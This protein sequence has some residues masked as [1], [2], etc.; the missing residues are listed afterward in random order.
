MFPQVRRVLATQRAPP[1]RRRVHLAH[2]ALQ[3]ALQRKFLAAALAHE[4]L[5]PVRQHML[6][7]GVQGLGGAAAVVTGMRALGRVH[8]RVVLE[9]AGV[10]EGGPA[11]LAGVRPLARVYAPVPPEGGTRG[12]QT[13]AEGASEGRL[14]GVAAPVLT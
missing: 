11:A 14:A 10:R 8:Q 6:A 12:E 5:L 9:C 3:V 7:H 13:W 1:R 4:S 2:M